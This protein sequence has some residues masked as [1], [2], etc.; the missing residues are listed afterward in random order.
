MLRVVAMSALSSS[1][2][3]RLQGRKN[4]LT[5]STPSLET[6]SCNNLHLMSLVPVDYPLQSLGHAAH[7][8][9]NR[10]HRRPSGA[11]QF[12]VVLE[13]SFPPAQTSRGTKRSINHH[14][15][16]CEFGGPVAEPFGSPENMLLRVL[17]Y[18]TLPST[19]VA[20]PDA[21][22]THPGRSPHAGGV[23]GIQPLDQPRLRH[24]HAARM[25]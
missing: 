14:D 2:H 12:H 1:M 20:S 18:E 11:F 5:P 24:A 10:I 25:R 16:T 22:W 21:T 23:C 17:T 9:G 15:A 3:A 7:Q 6:N 4:Y 13:E 19:Y 8:G